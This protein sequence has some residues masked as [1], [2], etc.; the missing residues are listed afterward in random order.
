[1]VAIQKAGLLFVAGA[2]FFRVDMGWAFQ[3]NASGISGAVAVEANPHTG[4]AS[5]AVPVDLPPGRGGIQPNVEMRYNS[6][7]PGGILGVGWSLDLGSIQRSTKKGV[8]RYDTSDTFILSQDS[9]TQE[10]VFDS[11]LGFYRLAIEGAFM[12]IEFIDNS[13]WRVTDKKGTRHY[14]GEDQASREHDPANT[15][16]VFKWALSRVEDV[17]GNAMTV[18]YLKADNKLYPEE[19]N[20]T[21]NSQA[22]LSSFGRVLL[23]YGLNPAPR[24]SFLSG[25]QIKITQRLSL[26]NVYGGG[27]LQRIYKLNYAQS[28]V[29]GRSLVTSIVPYGSDQT[30]AMPA[31]S[32][33]Y[34]SVKPAY[35]SVQPVGSALVRFPGDF[36]GDGF[37]DV[38]LFTSSSGE[39]GVALSSGAGFQPPQNWIGN[40]GVNQ[41]IFA[42]DF[43]ADGSGD[44]GSFEPSTGN[45]K[46]AYSTGNSF[47][48]MGNW[49][50]GFGVNG[51]PGTG[52]FN[53]DGLTDVINF[54]KTGGNLYGS[55][56][57][58]KGGYFQA[59]N[60]FDFYVGAQDDIPLTM[61]F[62]ADGLTDLVS[63]DKANGRW[64][65]YWNTV[66]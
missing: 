37:S 26:V 66:T 47:A 45:W 8:P 52:D 23:N 21:R 55:I 56:A 42:G 41:N 53:G 61:D 5:F 48:D 64:F 7:S 34:Q 29:T 30:T 18:S 11:S 20:Y 3:G 24:V 27:V 17:H 2:L 19:I 44:I 51:Q 60:G 14:F 39:V 15:A 6:G 33:V 57:V 49:I 25:F 43:N 63:F 40:F 13:Y 32:F 1:M 35:Y 22:G 9:G 31:E 10:L 28:A 46:V 36:N 65:V 16:R 59:L 58:N 62:N 38:A 12:K 4:S 54:Y 50:S